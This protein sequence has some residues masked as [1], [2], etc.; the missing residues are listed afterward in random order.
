MCRLGAC[1]SLLLTLFFDMALHT[2]TML[3][4]VPEVIQAF[5]SAPPL[6][7]LFLQSLHPQIAVEPTCVHSRPIRGERVVISLTRRELAKIQKK[8]TA[9]E[10]VGNSIRRPTAVFAD[11]HGHGE[12]NAPSLLLTG[13][14]LPSPNFD[15]AS[16]IA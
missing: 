14:V 11:P 5:F 1:E 16:N 9:N 15:D 6:P 2:L 4:S 10:V 12:S 3:P 8:K 13:R 7:T